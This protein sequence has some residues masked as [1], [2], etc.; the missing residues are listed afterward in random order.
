MRPPLALYLICNFGKHF[1]SSHKKDPIYA[2]WHFKPCVLGIL[3]TAKRSRELRVS[4]RH[5]GKA[6]SYLS[7]QWVRKQVKGLTHTLDEA[8]A[9]FALPP[10]WKN[11]AGL[12]GGLPTHLSPI[13]LLV[14]CEVEVRVHLYPHL[15]HHEDRTP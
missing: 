13:V 1:C 6:S 10:A 4:V 3:R 15:R 7:G 9:S 2:V 8:R 14:V 12:E 11:H 5:P